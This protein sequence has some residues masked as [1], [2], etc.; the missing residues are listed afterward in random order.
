MISEVVDLNQRGS[1]ER[2]IVGALKM[3]IDA[4]GP[5]TLDNVSSA[6]HR[7]INII[8]EH[9]RVLRKNTNA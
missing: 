6:A 5:I 7:V 2:K 1:L 4:H 9:N 8:K 3:A